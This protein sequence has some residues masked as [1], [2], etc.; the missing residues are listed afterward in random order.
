MSEVTVLSGIVRARGIA[1]SDALRRRAATA[2]SGERT[3]GTLP[4]RRDVD[5]IG[6]MLRPEIATKPSRDQADRARGAGRLK[7]RAARLFDRQT[8]LDWDTNPHTPRLYFKPAPPLRLPRHNDLLGLHRLIMG[9]EKYNASPAEPRHTTREAPSN[10]ANK[11]AKE[12]LHEKGAKEVL[13]VHVCG[14]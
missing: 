3:S 7:E 13:H 8:V 9:M 10:L 12:V 14:M 5:G 1:T 4:A 6:R 2:V 11:G